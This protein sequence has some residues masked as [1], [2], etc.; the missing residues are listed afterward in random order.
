MS[1]PI[2]KLSL[3]GA[4]SVFK[5][6]NQNISL[7][8]GKLF[9]EK[10]EK[11]LNAGDN[12]GTV[13]STNVKAKEMAEALTLQ[14]MQSSLN[15]SDNPASENSQT[16]NSA[17]LSS[18]K[19]LIEAYRSNQAE[20]ENE[21]SSTPTKI[22]KN[23]SETIPV[24]TSIK[25]S[26]LVVGDNSVASLDS[27]ISKASKKY[28]V[29]VGLIRAVIK[30]ES[31]FNSQAVSPVG[32]SGLMQLMPATARS[33]GVTNSFDPEQNVM[34]G[35]RFLKDMLKR[36]DGNIDSALAAYNWGPGNFERH[37]ERLPRETREYLTRV[38][39]LY[40]SYTA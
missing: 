2:E 7:E 16:S 22:I 1:I 23:A 12:S 9:S 38:K 10:F 19:N 30:V 36:Y 6:Q 3:L 33:L 11:A 18:L 5:P 4:L 34:A 39:Q 26:M 21:S 8:T 40:A 35:T 32:A 20:V 37:P 15:L 31:N 17:Q 28:G 29:E 24:A 25:D 13:A 27:V 14:M